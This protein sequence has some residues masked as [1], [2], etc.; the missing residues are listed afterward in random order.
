MNTDK[1]IVLS[2]FIGVHLWLIMPGSQSLVRRY[3]YERTDE[4][5]GAIELAIHRPLNL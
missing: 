5:A 2:V 4:I 1:E 3:L